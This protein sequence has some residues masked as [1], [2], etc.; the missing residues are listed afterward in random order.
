M[1]LDIPYAKDANPEK[2]KIK[3]KCVGLIAKNVLICKKQEQSNNIK[4][5]FFLPYLSGIVLKK[6]QPKIPPKKKSVLNKGIK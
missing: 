3:S 2:K 6:T 1:T 5:R 4:K